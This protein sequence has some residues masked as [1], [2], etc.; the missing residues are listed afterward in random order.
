MADVLELQR[1]LIMSG[2]QDKIQ[3]AGFERTFCP[4]SCDVGIPNLVA[5]WTDE[6]LCL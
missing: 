2:A 6:Q 5:G 4:P 3:K 1:V